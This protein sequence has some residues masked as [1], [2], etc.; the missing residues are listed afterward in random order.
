M[1][2]IARPRRQAGR[3]V[4]W[5]ENKRDIDMAQEI[6]AALSG[7]TE[8]LRAARRP[9]A[10]A[11]RCL[12]AGLDVYPVTLLLS[13]ARHVALALLK[14]AG[15]PL[16][17]RRIAKLMLARGLWQTKGLTPWRTANAHIVTE[18]KKR[19]ASGFV[20]RPHLPRPP[21]NANRNYAA[22]TIDAAPGDPPDE[23]QSQTVDRH[24]RQ[25]HRLPPLHRPRHGRHL[26]TARDDEPASDLR[27]AAAFAERLQR[28]GHEAVAVDAAARRSSK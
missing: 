16:H 24:R 2:E 19:A 8:S 22:P 1:A 15:E 9:A 23:R 10:A 11:I 21:F 7:I 4:R 17:H 13:L 25:R 18:M 6:L 5:A 28:F 12:V 26:R 20:R 27:S 14:N 3:A